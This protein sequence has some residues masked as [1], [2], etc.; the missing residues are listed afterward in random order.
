MIEWLRPPGC[1]SLSLG[2]LALCPHLC[3]P[4][5]FPLAGERK[6]DKHE[7]GYRFILHMPG[8][9]SHQT[10]FS[11]RVGCSGGG[12]FSQ[13]VEFRVVHLLATWH[14]RRD[15][16][17]CK[18][19]F[20]HRQE[21]T[22]WHVTHGQQQ[23]GLLSRKIAGE[24]RYRCSSQSGTGYEV[25]HVRQMCTWLPVYL[26]TTQEETLNNQVDKTGLC[27]DVSLFSQPPWN[28]PNQIYIPCDHSTIEAMTEN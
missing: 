5:G 27:L 15:D 22:H 16:L 25:T 12:K 26:A 21:Q 20:T 1:L 6:K 24:K 2:S 3:L 8:Q 9:N 10:T 23:T 13:W 7:P 28:L 11:L 18:Y 17:R 19:T 14:S 4:N